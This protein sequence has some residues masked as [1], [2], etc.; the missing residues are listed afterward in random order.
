MREIARLPYQDRADAG[1]QL[2]LLLDDIEVMEN[3]VVLAVPNGGVAVAT[4]VAKALHSPVDV[5]CVRRLSLPFAPE[6]AIGA[7]ANG[8][9]VLNESAIREFRISAHAVDRV[10]AREFRRLRRMEAR[11]RGASLPPDLSDRIAIIVDDGVATGSTVR[12]AVSAAARLGA[13]RIVVAVPVAASPVCDV[14]SREGIDLICPAR[15][16]R[17]VG[18]GRFYRSFPELSEADALQLLTVGSGTA[19]GP[20]DA[21]PDA[22]PE[23]AVPVV[24]AG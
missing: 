2:A 13:R 24:S 15:P 22:T 11:Y 12:A 17:F 7:I 8:V 10:V 9:R 6:F 23:D 18:I 19:A 3:V 1:R 5:L 20:F 21:E 4:E 16:R 14:L